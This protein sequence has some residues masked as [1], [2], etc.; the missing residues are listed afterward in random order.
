MMEPSTNAPHDAVF[1][2]F[3]MHPETARDFLDIHLPAELREICDLS[4]LQLESGTFI[5]DDLRAQ[6]S[7]VLYSLQMQGNDGYLHVLI[8]HQSSPDK[9]MAFRMIRYAIA[10]MHRHLEAGNEQLPLV[11]P[12]LFYQ[13]KVSPY[14]FSLCWLDMFASSTLAGRLYSQPFPLVDIT[15]IPDDD[16]M[17]HRRVAILELLQK[18][19]R[20][21][22]LMGL[23]APL[24]TLLHAEY[25]T[26]SQL[27]TLLNYMLQRGTT[28]QPTVFFRELTNRMP[29]EKTMQTLAQWL[30][31]QGMQ[32]GVAQGVREGQS[33]ERRIIARRL[34]KKGMAHEDVAQMTTLSLVE[35]EQL[36][37][38]R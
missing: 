35:V 20:Q 25:T 26:D 5:E 29:K 17:Q 21:R 13:G 31:E 22:D 15:V 7:D 12:I 28:H 16:I 33:E 30:E 6:Y 1:K 9:K 10:A 27:V 11:I 19:I 2:Q 14:P 32:K 38:W 3:L 34:L 8:E 4:T 36:I 24:V 23:L 37:D 18:H